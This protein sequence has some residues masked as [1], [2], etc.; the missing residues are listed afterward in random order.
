MPGFPILL[1]SCWVPKDPEHLQGD[2]LGYTVLRPS[3]FLKVLSTDPGAI[4][5]IF[6]CHSPELW[7]P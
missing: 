1:Q 6:V 7:R 5:L 2:S 3:G 4:G